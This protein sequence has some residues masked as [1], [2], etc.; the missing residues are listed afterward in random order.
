M[1]ILVE[2]IFYCLLLLALVVLSVNDIRTHEIPPECIRFIFMLGVI[3]LLTDLENWTGYVCGFFVV[4]TLLFVLWLVSSG[5]LIGGG[6]VKMM[7]VCGLV[8]G[9]KLI[10]IAFAVGCILGLLIHSVCMR[11]CNADK[12]LA[13]GPYFS[14]GVMS[15]ALCG[16]TYT[17]PFIEK[18]AD[19]L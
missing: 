9:W 8:L 1:Q 15:A 11:I 12:V 17:L 10:W 19:V 6:D 14:V 3:R 5:R 13:M 7:A 4:S 18:L 2:V 16:N